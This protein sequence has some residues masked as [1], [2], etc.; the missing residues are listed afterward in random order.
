MKEYPSIDRKYIKNVPIYAF[1]KLDGSNIRVEW[2]AKRGFYKFGTK[3]QLIDKDSNIFGQA[4]PLFI[5]KY[6]A[7]LV[8]VFQKQRWQRAICFVELYGKNTFAGHH[9]MEEKH[10]VTLFDVSI[11]DIILDPRDFIECFGHLDTA[12]LLYH[13]NAN[14][15][16]IKLVHNSEL[17][18]MTCEGVVCK[19]TVRHKKESPHMFKIKS[20]AW[21]DRLKG[22]CNGNMDLMARLL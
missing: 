14:E 9:D 20:N 3:T 16:F 13:G 21:I 6:E 1:D 5:E 11:D 2:S 8:K 17:E 12:S 4:V 22:Y 10:T 15:D 7:D 19:G 18:G